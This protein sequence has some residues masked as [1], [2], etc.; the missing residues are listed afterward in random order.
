MTLRRNMW[1]LLMLGLLLALCLVFSTALASGRQQDEYPPPQPTID[2]L[3]GEPLMPPPGGATPTLAGY[4]PAQPGIVGGTPVP[5]GIDGAGQL[6]IVPESA[7]DSTASPQAPG[8][9]LLYLWLGF[10]ATL[11]ILLTSVVGSIRLFTR[12]NET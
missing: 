7:A 3:R 12:R 2:P 5:I 4:P 1:P 11:L 9:G 10:L 8:R 6:P